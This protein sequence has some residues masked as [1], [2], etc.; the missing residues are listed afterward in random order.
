MDVLSVTNT[1]EYEEVVGL[2]QFVTDAGRLSS[3]PEAA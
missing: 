2:R 1:I 3:T